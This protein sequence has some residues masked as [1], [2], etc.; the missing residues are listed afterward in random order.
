MAN[1]SESLICINSLNPINIPMRKL[2]GLI[3]E[4]KN[5]KLKNI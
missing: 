2:L 1:C 4:M 5:L 3:F